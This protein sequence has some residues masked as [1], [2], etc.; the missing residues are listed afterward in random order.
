VPRPRQRLRIKSGERSPY[1]P[2]ISR[3]N[4]NASGVMRERSDRVGRRRSTVAPH[5]LALH[6]LAD[7]LCFGKHE[8]DAR[9][10]CQPIGCGLAPRR[11]AADGIVE[12][13]R[14][15]GGEGLTK[16]PGRPPGSNGIQAWLRDPLAHVVHDATLDFASLIRLIIFQNSVDGRNGRFV[17]AGKVP[18][19]GLLC[20]GEFRMINPSVLASYIQIDVCTRDW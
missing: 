1:T 2:F 6:N 14:A 8:T 10:S 17:L 13:P 4:C 20:M 12:N 11:G 18:S 9:A 5:N 7:P 15:A 19:Q 3:S 16:P